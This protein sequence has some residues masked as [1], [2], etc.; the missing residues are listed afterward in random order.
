MAADG[1]STRGYTMMEAAKEASDMWYNE[2]KDF[3]WRG[4][5]SHTGVVGHF[6]Q[7]K[8]IFQSREA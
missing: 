6:T 7:V 8:V 2:I 1:M 5:R 3:D 4:Y